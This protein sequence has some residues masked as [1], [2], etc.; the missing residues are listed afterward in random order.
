MGHDD[1]PVSPLL[2]HLGRTELDA[3]VAALAPVGENGH[4]TAR[5]FPF[6]FGFLFLYDLCTS[7]FT[8]LV[9]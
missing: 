7:R 6:W 3:Q 4:A 5:Q 8:H 2:Q 9:A 1:P